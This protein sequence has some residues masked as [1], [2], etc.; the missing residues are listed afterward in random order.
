METK[1]LVSRRAAGSG[2]P[3]RWKRGIDA[4][5]VLGVVACLAG[6]DGSIV[7]E[8]ESGATS[9][10]S[11]TASGG[12]TAS[13]STATSSG[14]TEG[15]KG[16][17]GGTSELTGGTG[18]LTGGSGGATE[19]GCTLDAECSSGNVCIQGQCVPGCSPD[20]ACAAGFTCCGGSCF[21]LATDQ[22]NCGACGDVCI[23][24]PHALPPAC[25]NG[26]CAPTGCEAG[27]ADCDADPSNG[28]EQNEVVDGTC[29]CAPGEVQPCYLGTPGTEGVGPC[30]AGTRTCGASGAGWGECTGQVLPAAEQCN[31]GVDDDCDGQ[32][33]VATDLDG[34]GFTACEGDCDDF[35]PKVNP[36]AFEDTYGVDPQTGATVE[37]LGNGI[38]D[39]CNPATPDV[40]IATCGDGEILSGVTALHLARAMDLC[41][42]AVAGV[43]K[44]QQ[45]W[46][47][48]SAELLRAD[49]TAPSAEQMAALQDLQT[50]TLAAYGVVTPQRGP[51]M[52]GLSTGKM[53]AP[54]HADYAPPAP[55]T[56]LGWADSPP[57]SY[58]QA[59]NGELPTS[60][61]CN[62]VCPP[63]SG[64]KD[65]VTLRL[66]V[67]AP[68]NAYGFS[69]RHQFLTAEYPM[70]VC[71]ARN[72][73]FLA[74][75]TTGSPAMPL[76]RN[77]AYDSLGN[78]VSIDDA[79]F[80][81]CA[82]PSGC[83]FCPL[84]VSGL[85]DTGMPASTGWLAANAPVL[86]GETITLDLTVFDGSD[87][88]VDS[89]VLLDAFRWLPYK[90]GNP[91]GAHITTTSTDG[92]PPE[93]I[94]T[95]SHCVIQ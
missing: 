5:A 12:A 43:P 93:A 33:D 51:S 57:P 39:D 62:G 90:A 23:S 21:D 79:S 65:G 61:A 3:G 49:G 86:I 84:G 70:S 68:T 56:D 92:L 28:C 54:S 85:T 22:N 42:T 44:A 69:F 18:G 19:P 24:F 76:D 88:A 17:T 89:V 81:A 9:S 77:V 73:F 11:T 64:A 35:N 60:H 59:H 1:A 30:H 7:Q 37:G 94:G 75:E 82:T 25:V 55:G 34:D 48:L 66:V 45:T 29:L 87:G 27:W 32:T 52:A 13:T 50:A 83:S 53:R 20:Q 40:G 6:C 80:Q 38:D 26:Q 47:L 72:D 36:G 8:N 10:T 46:G 95:K 63:S 71:A 78:P 58:L 74:L 41:Q 67:R 2:R 14:G 31:N 4:G 91:C 16:G 15:G